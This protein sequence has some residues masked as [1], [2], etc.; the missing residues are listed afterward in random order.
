MKED[1]LIKKLREA[2]KA[3]ARER[4]GNMSAGLLA[5]EQATDPDEHSSLLE[6]VF[7]EA[8][9]L[10]GAA[11]A[12]NLTGIEALCQTMENVFAAVR[13]KKYFFSRKMFDTLHAA[14]EAMED[15]MA[16]ADEDLSSLDGEKIV[17]LIQQL[18]ISGE[19]DGAPDPEGTR[20]ESAGG[21]TS[22]NRAGN[23]EKASGTEVSGE[24]AKDLGGQKDREIR[25]I[26]VPEAIT[27]PEGRGV[28]AAGDMAGLH[29]PGSA[30]SRPLTADTVRIS[31]A[32]LDALF[33]KTEELLSLKLVSNQHLD[34]LRSMV[35]SFSL[36]KKKWAESD[37]DFRALCRHVQ[38][39]DKLAGLLEFS[40]WNR[41]HLLAMEQEMGTLVKTA[42]QDSR[43]LCNMVD[44]LLDNMKETT[45]LPF[46][47][48]F[49]IL[50]R[51][52]RSIARDLGKDAD[53]FLQGGEVEIDRRILEELKDPIIHLLRN[54]IDHGLETSAERAE[55][56]KPAR[57]TITLTVSQTESSKVDITLSD[58][59][60]GID[61]E[62]VKA[63]A[64]KLG[65][66]S[67]SRAGQMDG[68]EALALIFR[69][70]VSTSAIITE[71]SGR[72]LGLAIV[73]ESIEKL[74]GFVGVENRPGQGTC[75][76][77]QVP[78]T[79]ATFRGILVR[80]GEHR[81][82][83]PSSHVACVLRVR[84]DEIKTVE[85]RA[86]ISL[87]GRAV[88]LVEL[89]GVLGLAVSQG[90]DDP[91]RYLTIMVLGTDD[92]RVGFRIDEVMG[93]QEVLVKGLGRQL[94]RV[95]N[96]A[97]ATILGDG[98]VVP[99]LNVRDLLASP[100]E[101]DGG[102]T[103]AAADSGSAGQAQKSVLVAEDS[104]T[105]R[106]LL[107][108]ILEGAGYLV[109]TAVDGMDAYTALKTQ[110][111]DVVVSDVEMPRMNGFELTGR[112]RDDKKLAETPV[113]LVTGLDSREDRER[114]IDGG[115]NAYSVKSSFDQSN[116]LEV[117][118]QLI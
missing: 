6:T 47:T 37:T 17:G 88:A 115:A 110:E 12:V 76:R 67:E 96:I 116:L 32:K 55:R 10:K 49:E 70:A 109:K 46:N 93:E 66:L 54:S 97:G 81:F 104:I 5:L 19:E 78:V 30:G 111:F 59:G 84:R 26:P 73:K 43:T 83:V 45:M 52:V 113:V 101:N 11:R 16:H 79:L 82:I 23:G 87:D 107:K 8:H 18:E 27:Q 38:D 89:D 102:V 117:I 90:H 103:G 74:G 85:G 63:G 108:N 2:F 98:K 42:E 75:F 65:I 60:R 94:V 15:F 24:P 112:I 1:E 86:A 50:P 9:S 92:Q 62:R 4:I 36:W 56:K 105:S 91:D 64:V 80:A 3:E 40:D 25:A 14:T 21:R 41:G 106:M 114:G 99:V 48:L 51:M 53:L 29:G 72:G 33:L 7:R 13:Q 68:E 57:G 69:S 31:T 71:I 39:H 58:D 20:K 118:R 22:E 34:N 35:Q 28:A 44:D 61:P 95:P 77:M 100:P